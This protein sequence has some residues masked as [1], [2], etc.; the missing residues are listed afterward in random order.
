MATVCVT[1]GS[2]GIGR[3]VCERFAATGAT[4]F[5]NYHANTAAA[6]EAAA[7]I[8][9]AGGTAHLVKFD[10]SS[11]DG[12]RQLVAK[13]GREVEQLD[14]LVH[15]A[16]RALPGPLLEIGDHELASSI[17]VNALALVNVTREA[18][19][20]LREGSTV[21][22]ITSRGGRRVLPGYGALGAAKALGE[23]LARYLA[24]ELAPRGI[25]VNSISPGPVD[26]AAYRA[27]FPDTWQ[28]RL[29]AAAQAMPPGRMV[30]AEEIAAVIE[31]LTRS[32]FSMVLGN[33]L[34]ID[35]GF[36]L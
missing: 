29:A 8:E 33:T 6:E 31:A 9:A 30:E 19:G 13:I 17:A 1:G 4:V 10:L 27:M 7:A 34:A 12:P 36:A 3:A 11:A 21:F 35:G 32:E 28:E 16:A 25:R 14:V 5:V 24:I 15:A 2:S 26:T 22:F 23:H 18:L 20:L